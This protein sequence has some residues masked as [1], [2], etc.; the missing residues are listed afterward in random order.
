MNAVFLSGGGARGAYEVGVLRTLL[1]EGPDIELIGGAS[2]GA[3]NAVLAATGQL[4][5][6]AEVWR[7]M[8]TLRVYRPRLDVWNFLKWKS[9]AINRGLFERLRDQVHWAHLP[10][11]RLQVFI[12]ATN[13]LLRKNQIFS[14]DEITYRHVMASAAIPILFPP[15]RI[16]KHWYIDGAFSLLRPLKPLVKAGA[17]RIFTVF[18]SPRRPRLEP[19]ADLFQMADRVLEVILSSAIAADREQIENTNREI[20]RLK[21]MDIDPA[22]FQHKPYRPV[23]VIAVHPSRDLGNVGSYIFISGTKARELMDLGTA[24]C[25]RVLRRH[26]LI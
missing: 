5:Q 18:L 8:S 17:S 21:A 12:S 23:Q 4:D 9:L 22:T 11:S 13:I 2:I 24:D 25:Y 26:E 16:G 10:H 14:N 6:L 19:P 1:K 3:I 20:E 7:H 15:V